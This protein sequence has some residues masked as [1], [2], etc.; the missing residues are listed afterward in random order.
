MSLRSA[1]SH[2][3]TRPAH[4]SRAV[5]GLPE[6][7]L[8][9]VLASAELQD[10]VDTK[11]IVAPTQMAELIAALAGRLRVLTINGR[12]QFAYDSIYF[13]TPDLLTLRNHRQ[14]R[15]RRFKVRTR[16]YVDSELSVLEVKVKGLRGRTEKVR[17]DH[18][19]PPDRLDRA[20]R[21][22]VTEVLADYGLDDA[23]RIAGRLQPTV[24]TTYD[25][26]TFVGAYR[27]VRITADVHLR[28]GDAD[29]TVATLPDS[30][31]LEVKTPG[32]R[33][34]IL[35]LL[36]RLGARPVRMSKYGAG[37][38]MVKDDVPPQPWHPVITRHLRPT[39]A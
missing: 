6:V 28:C 12:R 27:P 5:D 11:F 2:P 26:T 38:A 13:D 37:V 4:L 31:L 20:A 15:R 17:I 3:A 8:E 36:H 29:R 21:D 23:A 35:T 10:R 32:D 14:G 9:E 18:V 16:T 7:S 39:V 1:P 22:F 34:P 25:R 19:G 30:I 33:D 24:R